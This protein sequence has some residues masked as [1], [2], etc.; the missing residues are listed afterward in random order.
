M[1]VLLQHGADCNEVDFM[2]NTALYYAVRYRDPMK[3][4]LLLEHRV[5]PSPTYGFRTPSRA[6]TEIWLD[7]IVEILGQS[8]ASI[9]TSDE[10]SI[11]TWDD[12]TIPELCK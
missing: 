4:Y 1:Q 12:D 9:T 11:H 6:L 3:V 8:R 5:D 10:R 2:G 7:S